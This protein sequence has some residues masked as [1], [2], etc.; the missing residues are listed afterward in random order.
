M[1]SLLYL[2]NRSRLL[3]GWTR[4]L[5]SHFAVHWSR[6][7]W[8]PIVSIS[9]VYEY[10]SIIFY[11][12]VLR[13]MCSL[14]FADP[15]KSQKSAISALEWSFRCWNDGDNG[16]GG[17]PYFVCMHLYV[18]PCAFVKTCGFPQRML[19]G[20]H[21]PEELHRHSAYDSIRRFD[22]LERDHF[23]PLCQFLV[24]SLFSP[25]IVEK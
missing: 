17:G 13:S 5:G 7:L 4:V 3:K 22:S 21:S 14:L 24:R 9:S 15:S 10:E 25:N 19:S 11:C 2:I 23:S 8:C 12:W 18:I 1:L 20:L 6:T 16:G